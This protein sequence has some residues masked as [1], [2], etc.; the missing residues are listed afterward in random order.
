MNYKNNCSKSFAALI[1]VF[2]GLVFLLSGCAELDQLMKPRVE[3]LYKAPGFDGDALTKGGLGEIHVQSNLSS[4]EMNSNSL[5]MMLVAAIREKRRDVQISQS[6]AYEVDATLLANDVTKRSDSFDTHLYRW[7]KRSV[8]VSY[9]ITE[10]ETGKPVWNGIIDT[11]SE[12]IASYEFDQDEKSRD[13]VIKSAIAALNKEDR[14]PYPSAPL[15]SEV[16]KTN[17]QGFA[18]NLPRNQ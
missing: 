16:A 18:L 9:E 15:L 1:P 10:S 4:N 2:L 3:G 6:G 13:K 14:Y 17:F 7:T 8:K 12:S 5:E 11:N